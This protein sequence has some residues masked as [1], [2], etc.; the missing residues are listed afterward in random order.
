MPS[1]AHLADVLADVPLLSDAD[2]E[3]TVIPPREVAAD[4]AAAVA[5]HVHD[6][7]LDRRRIVEHLTEQPVFP[8][9]ERTTMLLPEALATLAVVEQWWLTRRDALSQVAP[10]DTVDVAEGPAQWE[11][12]LEVVEGGGVVEVTR[13][14]AVVA[15]VVPAD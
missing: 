7:F 2:G 9:E 11:R 10:A 15:R 13:D 6:R 1:A 3:Q 8:H 12:L 5:P 14:G 4:I